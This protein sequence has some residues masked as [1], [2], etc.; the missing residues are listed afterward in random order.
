MT[1][2]SAKPKCFI[3]MPI[4]VHDEEAAL[5]GDDAHWDHVM[6]HLFIPAIEKAGFDPVVPTAAGTS[7]IHGRIVKYLS[8]CELVLVDLSRHNPNVLFE[9][10]VRT[11]LNR[12]VALVKDEHLKLPFDI[13]GLNTHHYS[14]KLQ[15]WTIQAQ[16]DDLS[17][18]ITDSVEASGDT[19]PLWKH[20]GVSI[21]A[22]QPPSGVDP[23]DATMQ[24]LLER[25][26]GIERA[27]A[28]PR[29]QARSGRMSD[30]LAS[31]VRNLLISQPGVRAVEV[32]ESHSGWDQFTVRTDARSSEKQTA[33]I[34]RIE[35]MLSAGSLQATAIA[36]D[37]D[38]FILEV[39]TAD[40]A[41]LD[42]IVWS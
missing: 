28:R 8:E 38:M 39:R 19:N 17:A 21:A 5:Y 23:R 29:T 4:T 13:Q 40:T 15:P 41:G 24:L 2:D 10:G 31:M 25:M 22:S 12:P 30:K 14:S 7:M 35:K 18:H 16:I 37:S 36:G 6:R 20:F 3:A 27:V 1:I 42:D 26:E 34:S 33:E 11:S 9:L 32:G